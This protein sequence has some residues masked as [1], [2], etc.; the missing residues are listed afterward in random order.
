MALSLYYVVN[1]RISGT[2]SSTNFAKPSELPVNA[3]K[4]LFRDAK[5]SNHS[6]I[7]TEAFNS[8]PMGEPSA[9][10]RVIP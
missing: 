10:P 3:L 6:A 5:N 2:R 1:L 9:E 4:D 8:I 7:G